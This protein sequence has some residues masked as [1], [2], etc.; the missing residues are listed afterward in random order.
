VGASPGEG[1][2]VDEKRRAFVKIA[3]TVSAIFAAGGIGAIAKSVVNPGLTAAPTTF[4]RVKVTNVSDLT[5]NTP[6]AFNYPLDDEPNVLVKLGQQVPDGIG[7]QGDIVAYSNVCQH[8]GCIYGFQAKG[9]SPSCN[10][11]YRADR[12]VG[13]CCCH[14]SVYDLSNGAA[15]ISGPAPRPLPRV[16]LEIDS[17]GDVYATGMTPPSIF[18]HGTGS[19]DVTQDLQG[20]N[21]VSS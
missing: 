6:V 5:V 8:L 10:P 12:P 13:Y 7:P 2:R 1:K 3:V 18:G 4:P 21:V 15:V 20:G 19:G 16:L 11:S 9:T 14:G 17:A